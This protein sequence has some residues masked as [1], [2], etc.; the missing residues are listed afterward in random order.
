MRFLYPTA[1]DTPIRGSLSKY[2]YNVWR[3]KNN[4][5]AIPDGEK[6]LMTRLAVLTQSSMDGQTHLTT[7]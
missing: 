5:V 6:K 7:A 3:G 4:G 2:C 1:F